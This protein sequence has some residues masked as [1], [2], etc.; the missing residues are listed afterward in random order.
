MDQLLVALAARAAADEE[1]A[2][3]STR[4][5]LVIGV[6]MLTSLSLGPPPNDWPTNAA[7]RRRNPPVDL[8][9]SR[10]SPV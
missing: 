3:G 6:T 8:L 5:P 9:P 7:R 1:A 2:R 10:L 4:P